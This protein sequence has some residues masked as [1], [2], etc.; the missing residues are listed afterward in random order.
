MCSFS[1]L[2]ESGMPKMNT[3]LMFI[4]E[5]KATACSWLNNVHGSCYQIIV[6]ITIDYTEKDNLNIQDFLYIQ[7]N[8]HGRGM[9]SPLYLIHHCCISE[10][11]IM[12]YHLHQTHTEHHGHPI[13]NLLFSP[14]VMYCKSSI[15]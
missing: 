10:H 4:R 15:H 2:S 7:N 9:L 1:F 5:Y 8:G 12:F 3:I 14:P 13:C 6:Y 11:L